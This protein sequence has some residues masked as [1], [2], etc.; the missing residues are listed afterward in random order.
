MVLH[1]SNHYCVNIEDMNWNSV[2]KS[3][4]CD[5]KSAAIMKPSRKT[6]MEFIV[7]LFYKMQISD[8]RDKIQQFSCE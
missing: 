8:V 1:W 3:I 5:E 7:H 2:A 4:R 6:E